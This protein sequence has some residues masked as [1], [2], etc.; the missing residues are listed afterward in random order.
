[1]K[2]LLILL[3]LFS[4]SFSIIQKSGFDYIYSNPYSINNPNII[5]FFSFDSNDFRGKPLPICKVIFLIL[6]F[7]IFFI[8]FKIYF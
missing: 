4:I 1:M 6:I 7:F 8:F 5:S 2:N 3:F